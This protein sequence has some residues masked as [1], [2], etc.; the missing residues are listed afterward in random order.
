M[1]S[2]DRQTSVRRQTSI[3]ML[4]S[5]TGIA[6]GALLTQ[7]P[8]LNVVGY[9]FSALMGFAGAVIGA[10]AGISFGSRF[11]FQPENDKT[12]KNIFIQYYQSVCIASFPVAIVYLIVSIHSFFFQKCN[13]MTGLF[14]LIVIPSILIN[15]AGGLAAA[16]LFKNKSASFLFVTLFFIA[17]CIHSLLVFYFSPTMS[18]P[19][20][21]IGF[22]SVTGFTGYGMSVPSY[23]ILQRAIS[24]IFA[25]IFLS[26]ASVLFKLRNGKSRHFFGFTTISIAGLSIVALA[27][28][29]PYQSGLGANKS[30][31][32][33]EL[34]KKFVTEH[35]IIHYSPTKGFDPK[36]AAMFGEWYIRSIKK[37]IDSKKVDKITVYL[38]KSADQMDNLFGASDYFFTAPW[39]REIH[40]R[41]DA[42]STDIFKHEL[43]H[44]IMGTYSKGILK[45][46][47][48]MGL[49]EGTATAIEKNYFRGPEF[50]KYF[51]AALKVGVIA[52][53]EETMSATGFGSASMFKSYN[54]AGGFIGYLIYFYGPEKFK[55]FYASGNAVS[56]YGKNISDLGKDWYRWLK[57]QS[58]AQK[59]MAFAELIYSNSVNPAF[60]KTNCPRVGTHDTSINPYDQIHDLAADGRIDEA[61]KLCSSAYPDQTSDY[62]NLIKADVL[63]EVKRYD[64]AI[65]LLEPIA[66][67][68]NAALSDRNEAL[69]NLA[70]AYSGKE[71]YERASSALTEKRKL[72]LAFPDKDEAVFRVLKRVKSRRFFF[73]LFCEHSPS[74]VVDNAIK[75]DPD[76]GVL[77]LI[78]IRKSEINL[79]SP[80]F[81][82]FMANTVGMNSTKISLLF[83]GGDNAALSH[84]YDSAERAYISIM[85]LSDDV[86]TKFE[87][88]ERLNRIIFFKNYRSPDSPI[89]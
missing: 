76:F 22:V 36:S 75:S 48:N 62:R 59:D 19:N 49:I 81:I 8:L 58:A 34:P 87:A 53:P 65:N 12:L 27:F 63:I 46:P 89:R 18:V 78:R 67:N 80:D 21:T 35:L 69:M 64:L 20:I 61:L 32:N 14:C 4:L 70:C 83:I 10:C 15:A 30:L 47:Y 3:I 77:R 57:T 13:M 16:R 17:T 42:V 7:I 2:V 44:A 25:V 11:R 28:F 1:A 51:A 74:N 38:Y 29:F 66:L 72:G 26:I 85:A 24:C 60:F 43:V 52:P 41:S 79:K 40:I 73:K 56:V 54:M 9:E 68:K 86:V 5:I 39:R 37:G 31:L 71:D 33:K 82:S 84:D 55:H 50:Q 45:V 6:A 88:K 23:L